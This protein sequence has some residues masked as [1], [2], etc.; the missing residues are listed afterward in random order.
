M[1]DP[2][3]TV[4]E[5]LPILL[6]GILWGQIWRNH[7]VLCHCDNQAVVSCLRSRTS[8]Q[9]GMMHNLVFIEA[10]HGFHFVPH[11]IDIRANHLADDLSRN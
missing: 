5:L 10:H 3:I 2:P 6:A 4:K 11:Y 9:K 8:K 7:R 1:F